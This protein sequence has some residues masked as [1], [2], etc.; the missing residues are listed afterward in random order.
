MV[1]GIVGHEASKFTPETEAAAR[2]AIGD[3]ITMYEPNLIVSGACHLGGI[4]IWAEEEAGV[5]GVPFRAFPPA[6]LNWADGYKPRNIQIAEASDVVVCLAVAALPEGYRGMRFPL[7]YHC[8]TT[9]HVKC[10]GCWTTKYA[11]AH[12]KD[13]YTLVIDPIDV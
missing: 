10:G 12:G 9:E 13:G 6:V 1:L 7:C 2:I 4:D 3:L 5:L 8:R 11:R